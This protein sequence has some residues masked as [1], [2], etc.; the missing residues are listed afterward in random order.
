MTSTRD[1]MFD[2]IIKLSKRKIT[3]KMAPI[4]VS[5]QR[6][7]TV[8]P[9]DIV[10]DDDDPTADRWFVKSSSSSIWYTISLIDAS[11]L[12]PLCRHKCKSCATCIHNF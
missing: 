11:C 5:H 6:S 4:E 10:C 3:E 8:K 9:E 7:L 1:K 2:R 12:E